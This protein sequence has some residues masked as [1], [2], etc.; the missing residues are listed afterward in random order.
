MANVLVNGGQA[1]T[2]DMTWRWQPVRS[3]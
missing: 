2:V 1:Q 3:T